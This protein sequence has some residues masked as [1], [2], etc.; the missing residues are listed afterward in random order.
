MSGNGPPEEQ[1][2]P[3]ITC[4]GVAPWA[5]GVS[6]SSGLA[7]A[8]GHPV[9]SLPLIVL[10]FP[11]FSHAQSLPGPLCAPCPA[12]LIA[13]GEALAGVKEA[14]WEEAVSVRRPEGPSETWRRGRVLLGPRTRHAR[15][16]GGRQGTGLAPWW[17]QAVPLGRG[18]DTERKGRKV[19]E[20]GAGVHRVRPRRGTV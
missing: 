20:D 4:S 15:L 6:S 8:L 11:A 12:F 13:M 19:Q 1:S 7:S 5:A 18:R 10:S 17:W 2:S 3:G 9:P 14:F 16:Y